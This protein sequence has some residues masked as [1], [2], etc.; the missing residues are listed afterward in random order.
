MLIKNAVMDNFEIKHPF[1]ND[2]SFL[3]GTIFIGP[4]I[5]NDADSRNV[6]IFADGEVN[7]S[8]AGT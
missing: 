4:P 8:P 7:R 2:L 1:D 5:L 6:S 3:Y